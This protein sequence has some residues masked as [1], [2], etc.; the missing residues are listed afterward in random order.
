MLPFLRFEAPGLVFR[1]KFI[2]FI[3]KHYTIGRRLT[4][5]AGDI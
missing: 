4:N 2:R 5:R 1:A 3:N